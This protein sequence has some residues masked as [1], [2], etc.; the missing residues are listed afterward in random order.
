MNRPTVMAEVNENGLLPLR[1][2]IIGCYAVPV[3]IRGIGSTAGR[4]D[5]ASPILLAAGETLE[6]WSV[7]EAGVL[8]LETKIHPVGCDCE[9]CR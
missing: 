9:S 5:F 3:S 6:Y 4:I 7:V 2:K 1:G 8:R